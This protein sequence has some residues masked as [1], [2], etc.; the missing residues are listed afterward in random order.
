MLQCG[1]TSKKVHKD[2]SK[3]Q[4]MKLEKQVEVQQRH[5]SLGRNWLHSLYDAVCP[6]IFSNTCLKCYSF[7]LLTI[8]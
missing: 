4:K 2:I 1:W 6:L 5:M 7:I 8:N 3:A